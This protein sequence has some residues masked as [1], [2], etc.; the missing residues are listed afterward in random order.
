[1]FQRIARATPGSF[2]PTKFVQVGIPRADAAP[3]C[4]PGTANQV[5]APL[6]TLNESDTPR[7]LKHAAREGTD[8]PRGL[9]HA[10]RREDA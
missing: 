8:T 2:N 10:A 4:D 6:R 9:K 7:E 3:M 5:S 1:M